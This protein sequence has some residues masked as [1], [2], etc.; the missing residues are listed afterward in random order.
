MQHSMLRFFFWTHIGAQKR[1]II[2]LKPAKMNADFWCSR[3]SI[4]ALQKK[5]KEGESKHAVKGQI[6]TWT[7]SKRFKF[8]WLSASKK[9][10]IHDS[11]APIFYSIFS[12][13]IHLKWK[14]K[15]QIYNLKF[16]LCH[17]FNKI[18]NWNFQNWIKAKYEWKI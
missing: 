3:I 2:L 16:A 15:L 13:Q 18:L 12:V 4:I 9:G 7:K 6:C 1:W 14:K 8:F 10:K 11:Y 17:F 5:K